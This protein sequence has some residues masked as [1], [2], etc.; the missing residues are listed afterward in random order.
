MHADAEVAGVTRFSMRDSDVPAPQSS[1][2]SSTWSAKGSDRYAPPGART[3]ARYT[4]VASPPRRG[5]SVGSLYRYFSNEQAIQY[6]LQVD[7]W[8]KTG[9]AL[10]TLSTDTSRCAR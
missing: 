8:Q 5:V 1:M 4:T 7:E 9:A 6:R 2:D 10:H 3:R